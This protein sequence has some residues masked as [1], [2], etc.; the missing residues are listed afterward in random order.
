VRHEFSRVVQESSG[1]AAASDGLAA[2]ERR[3]W[4]LRE[5]AM[6]LVLRADDKRANEL[7]V[8]LIDLWR[9]S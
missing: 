1:L 8:T 4:S 7:R 9:V 5:A 2:P 6:L 3:P